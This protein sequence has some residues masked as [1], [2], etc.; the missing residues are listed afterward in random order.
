MDDH[1]WKSL[2]TKPVDFSVEFTEFDP[3]LKELLFVEV[4]PSPRHRLVFEYANGGRFT[5]D[6]EIDHVSSVVHDGSL[7]TYE[8][9]LKNVNSVHILRTINAMRDPTPYWCSWRGLLWEE[10]IRRIK[11]WWSGY[12]HQ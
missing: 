2:H 3:A 5:A 8:V 12:K 6:A 1:G 11:E 4:E 10:P 9:S 7:C